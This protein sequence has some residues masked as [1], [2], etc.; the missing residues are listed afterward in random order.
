MR[1]IMK[2]LPVIALSGLLALMPVQAAAQEATGQAFMDDATC[3]A[4]PLELEPAHRDLFCEAATEQLAPAARLDRLDAA[5]GKLPADNVASAAL[6]TFRMLALVELGRRDEA[7]AD[8]RQTMRAFPDFPPV[9]M[10]AIGAFTFTEHS[11]A[12]ADFWIELSR[13]HPDAAR[14]IEGYYWLTL[15]PNLGS[16]GKQEKQQQLATALDAIGY[17]GGSETSR[18]LLARILFYAEM[19][20]GDVAEAKVHLQRIGDP[21]ILT[22]ILS[23]E[24][25]SAVWEDNPWA[26]PDRRAPIVREWV[27]N[28][29]R[30]AIADGLQTSSFFREVR[31]H[32]GPDPLVE[33]YEPVLRAQM[34]KGPAGLESFDL[35]FWLPSLAMAHITA[36]RPDKAEALYRDA[37]DFFSSIDSLVRLNATSNYAL[38]LQEQGRNAEALPLI[39]EAIDTL[40]SAGGINTEVL[41]MHAV[42]AQALVGLG[43]SREAEESIRVLEE[44]RRVSFGTYIDTMLELGRFEQARDA[45][46]EVLGSDDYMRAV[47]LLQPSIAAFESPFDRENEALWARL[48]QDPQV[49]RALVGKGRVLDLEP[50]RLDGMVLPDL[51]PGLLPE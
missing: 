4:L 29:G 16:M 23:N 3:Y 35:S 11:E 43:R 36:G 24:A 22:D 33:A 47:S 31:K 40:F 9:W 50:I 5:I 42:R 41:Q 19:D 14:A 26:D 49:Q 13:S 6:R 8:V 32:V 18:S 7:L 51:A 39:E 15:G 38:F 46:V 10:E 34:A 28:L 27:E 45:L 30:A 20:H 17:D 48:G 1:K 44:N 25:L 2:S 12:A 37:V 21:E